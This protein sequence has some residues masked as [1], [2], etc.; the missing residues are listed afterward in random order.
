MN[1]CW[2]YIWWVIEDTSARK[3]VRIRIFTL[4]QSHVLI[5][6]LLI[7]THVNLRYNHICTTLQKSERR[8]KDFTWIEMRYGSSTSVGSYPCP[9]TAG[10]SWSRVDNLRAGIASSVFSG[11]RSV[12]ATVSTRRGCSW[13]RTH[14]RDS[15]W[16]SRLRYI[17]E[18]HSRNT[19]Y[20]I[21][22]I[23]SKHITN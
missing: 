7:I 15:P 20:R 16:N 4:I 1:L 9:V 5:I 17:T 19:T 8:N 13:T 11:W 3:N 21:Y 6:P 10:T 23:D 22:W 12:L 2:I 14:L 18:H